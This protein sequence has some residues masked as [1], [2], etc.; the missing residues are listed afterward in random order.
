MKLVV[1]AI[2]AEGARDYGCMD[3]FVETAAGQYELSGE[4]GTA[5]IHGSKPTIEFG[6]VGTQ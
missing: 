5:I 2:D 3:T 4:F 6:P 1:P